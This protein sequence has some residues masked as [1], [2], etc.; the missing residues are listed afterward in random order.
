MSTARREPTTDFARREADLRERRRAEYD[1][2][3]DERELWQAK[4][5]A[6]YRAIERLARFVIPRGQSVLEIGCGTGDLLAA[7]EPSLGV[8]VDLSPR[9]CDRARRKHPR[10]EIHEGDAESLDIAAL[11]GR[12]FDYVVLSDVVGQLGDVW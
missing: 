7:L 1:R 2:F 6:Y 10:L 4:N 11:E 9:L 12:T 3:A 8:G 5:A